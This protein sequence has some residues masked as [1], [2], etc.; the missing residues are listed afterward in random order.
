MTARTEKQ[1]DHALNRAL[2]ERPEFAQWFLSKTKFLEEDAKYIWSRA[3]HPWGKVKIEVLNTE[4]GSTEVIER[5]GE[6]DVLVVFETSRKRRVALHIENKLES[7]RF[8]HLQPELY[9]AR[10]AA[11]KESPKY[12]NYEDWETVLV[13]PQS[14][15]ERHS[16]DARKFG[17]FI[18]HEELAT[19][20]P[21]FGV[22]A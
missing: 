17:S 10:A 14:F 19:F 21:E 9:S 4:T 18:S 13:A 3:N 20:I 11:W 12:E 15:Y 6:T 8:T 7:G 2:L 5:E 16:E 1:L 22:S